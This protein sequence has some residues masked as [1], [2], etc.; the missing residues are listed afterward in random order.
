MLMNYLRFVLKQL[1]LH[2]GY[3][4]INILGLGVGITVCMIIFLWVQDELRFDELHKNTDQIRRFISNWEK[5][6]WDGLEISQAALAPAYESSNYQGV[7]PCL[8]II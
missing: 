5:Q 8:R 3:S 1:R 7:K 2:K 4:L 6:G